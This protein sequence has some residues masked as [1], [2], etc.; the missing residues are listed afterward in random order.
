MWDFAVRKVEGGWTGEA[1]VL[2]QVAALPS[3]PAGL[4]RSVSAHQPLEER[5]LVSTAC[6][7]AG[8]QRHSTASRR[9]A[10][11]HRGAAKLA[12][13]GHRRI[14]S[15]LSTDLTANPGVRNKV[16]WDFGADVKHGLTRGLTADF[17]YNTDFAQ[18]EADEQQVNLSRFSLFFPEKRDFSSRT[19]DL[20]LRGAGST[21]QTIFDTPI[22]FHAAAS[23]ST[24]GRRSRSVSAGA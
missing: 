10:G 3:G 7:R 2:L 24:R 17:T 12:G 9:H 8:H 6:P 23:A 11:R 18:V 4:G 13:A 21:S 15:D 1:A 5:D 19:R 20:Q 16:G 14:T 22:M